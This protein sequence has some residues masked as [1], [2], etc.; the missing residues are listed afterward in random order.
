[1]NETIE[2]LQM[3]IAYQEDSIEQL[4]RIIIK[5]QS[6]IDLLK[7]EIQQLKG[8]IEEVA[9]SLTDSAAGSERPPHY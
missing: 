8:M 2:D 9:E 7:G 6:E 5:Q 1:M 4:N 3:R